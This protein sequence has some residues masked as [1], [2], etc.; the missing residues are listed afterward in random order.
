MVI[1]EFDRYGLQQLQLGL[2]DD[3]TQ[4]LDEYVD[5]ELLLEELLT[6]RVDVSIR[7][8]DGGVVLAVVDEIIQVL[9]ALLHLHEVVQVVLLFRKSS[10]SRERL[11][12][13]LDQ[14]LSQH[15]EA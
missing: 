8:L 11:L 3:P 15:P 14:E 1:P 12:L 9:N 13:Y 7:L 10:N 6:V 2:Q 5:V 4:Y